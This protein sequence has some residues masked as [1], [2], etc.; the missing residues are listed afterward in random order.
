MF[1][2]LYFKYWGTSL[3]LSFMPTN[4]RLLLIAFTSVALGTMATFGFARLKTRVGLI[5]NRFIT[6]SLAWNFTVWQYISSYIAVP[7]T[8][9]FNG[10][11][12]GSTIRS[13]C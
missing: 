1:I 4:R 10:K 9:G 11:T 13:S 12:R 8:K 2:V 7:I 3:R 6:V 5:T